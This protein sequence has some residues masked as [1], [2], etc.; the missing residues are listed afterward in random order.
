MSDSFDCFGI[1]PGIPKLDYFKGGFILAGSYKEVP[2]REEACLELPTNG[3]DFMALQ[4]A[5]EI[6]RNKVD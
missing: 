3:L 1:H 5:P 2:V 4:F 6:L